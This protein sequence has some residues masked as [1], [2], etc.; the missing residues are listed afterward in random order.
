MKTIQEKI[1][2]GEYL[3]KLQY[4]TQNDISKIKNEMSARIQTIKDAVGY[5]YIP[6]IKATLLIKE[7]SSSLDDAQND[8]NAKR[9]KYNNE[10]DRLETNF[11]QD[12]F[13]YYSLYNL[14]DVAKNEIYTF[15]VNNS[16][17][18]FQGI[19]DMVS[20]LSTIIKTITGE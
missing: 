6:Q 20:Q 9:E 13:D 1:N 19:N 5:G 16:D 2:Q 11:Q 3:N 14:T 7:I 18:S 15:A 10:H 8:F 4:P 12:L 17:G